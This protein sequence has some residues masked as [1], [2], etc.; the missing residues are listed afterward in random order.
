MVSS[1]RASASGALTKKS[2]W[3]PEVRG[4]LCLLRE[5]PLA[6]RVLPSPAARVSGTDWRSAVA[7]DSDCNALASVTNKDSSVECC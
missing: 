2:P 7:F 3:T 5:Q 4:R 1:K 6:G